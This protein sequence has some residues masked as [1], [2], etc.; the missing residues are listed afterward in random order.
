MVFHFEMSSD[1]GSCLCPIEDNDIISCYGNRKRLET[2][3]CF[4]PEYNGKPQTGE[5]LRFCFNPIFSR[6]E[7]GRKSITYL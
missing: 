3:P 5:Q 1:S 4:S 6:P 7:D 2:I